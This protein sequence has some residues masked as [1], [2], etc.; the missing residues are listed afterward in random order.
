MSSTL[1]LANLM[2]V[3]K[4]SQISWTP[5]RQLS[6]NCSALILKFGLVRLISLV[7]WL[8]YLTSPSF[9][10]LV[11]SFSRDS[12]STLGD[13]TTKQMFVFKDGLICCP[14]MYCTEN[15]ELSSSLPDT[16]KRITCH[17]LVFFFLITVMIWLTYLIFFFFLHDFMFFLDKQYN[18]VQLQGL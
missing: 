3:G 5:A 12:T 1:N 4:I 18:C 8:R 2:Q 7:L 16:E 10:L 11:Q 6:L 13:I 17:I 15:C 14:S 9:T